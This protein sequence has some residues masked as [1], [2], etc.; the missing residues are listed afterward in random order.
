MYEEKIDLLTKILGVLA[1]LSGN[2]SHKKYALIYVY[3][4]VCQN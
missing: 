2:V 3:I 4:N 1:F